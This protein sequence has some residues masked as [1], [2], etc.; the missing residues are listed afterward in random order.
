MG[1]QAQLKSYN[2]LGSVGDTMLPSV[3]KESV[4]LATS[5]TVTVMFCGCWHAD[6]HE[7]RL[8]ACYHVDSKAGCRY[9]D[10]DRKAGRRHED[11]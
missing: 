8:S 7:G 10:I 3:G 5:E 1:G 2:K 4:G 9:G 6:R 11:I